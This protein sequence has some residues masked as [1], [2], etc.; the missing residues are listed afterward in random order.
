MDIGATATAE[1]YNPS[2]TTNPLTFC[3]GCVRPWYVPN[4]DPNNT[5]P[6]N[7]QCAPAS[8][9]NN[10]PAYFV[11]PNNK[12][13]IANNKCVTQGGPIGEYFPIKINRE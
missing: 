3:T 5:S 2:G 13:A 9:G 8:N 12:Y 4:C 6:A 11:D 1:A 7:S 10:T